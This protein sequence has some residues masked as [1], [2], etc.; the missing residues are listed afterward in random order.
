[1]SLIV[2]YNFL[3]KSESCAHGYDTT[4]DNRKIIERVLLFWPMG[5]WDV[6]DSKV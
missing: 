3:I 6:T 5:W 4:C 2:K 1:M